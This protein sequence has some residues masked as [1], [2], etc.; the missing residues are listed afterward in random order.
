MLGGGG[1]G[2][3]TVFWEGGGGHVLP[4]ISVLTEGCGDGIGLGKAT[5][6]TELR[7]PP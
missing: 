3:W 4:E 6:Q 5:Q 1:E 2:S 7:S